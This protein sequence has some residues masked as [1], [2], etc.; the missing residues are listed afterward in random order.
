MCTWAF[1]VGPF[2]Y[3]NVTKKKKKNQ[4]TS[5][6]GLWSP[7]S[8]IVL[9]DMGDIDSSV[10]LRSYGQPILDILDRLIFIVWMWIH[11]CKLLNL[12]NSDGE[13]QGNFY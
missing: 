2:I 13:D 4:S 5:N 10:G 9:A 12:C 7:N 3:S 1:G 11:E 8:N 6:I